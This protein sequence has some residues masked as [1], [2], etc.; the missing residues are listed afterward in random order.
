MATRI[1]EYGGADRG[2]RLQIVPATQKVLE[3][4]AMTATA[5]STQS[6]AVDASTSLVLVQSDEQIYVAL[7]TNPTATTNSYRLGAGNEQ[8]FSVTP[9]KSWKVAIRT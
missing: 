8:W 7:G 3:Q 4:T 5:T 6:P 1:I 9:N 2:D